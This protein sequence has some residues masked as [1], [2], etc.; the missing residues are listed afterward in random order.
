VHT[1]YLKHVPDLTSANIAHFLNHKDMQDK[2]FS[3]NAFNAKIVCLGG[4]SVVMS[5]VAKP[6]PVTRH[7][8]LHMLR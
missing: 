8:L 5:S 3:M 4:A 2:V 6:A 7:S 1:N